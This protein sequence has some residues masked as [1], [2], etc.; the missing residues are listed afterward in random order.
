MNKIISYDRENDILC[1]HKGFS[2][3][4]KF[5]GNIDAGDFVLDVSTEGKVRGIEIMNAASFLK[6]FSIS[7]KTLETLSDANFDVL[8]KPNSLIIGLVIKSKS[9]EIPAKIA[10]PLERPICR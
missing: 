9:G 3:N 7:K 1:I 8:M 4:E 2:S 10:V 5:K 6:E